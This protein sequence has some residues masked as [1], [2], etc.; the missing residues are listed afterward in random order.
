[1]QT[2]HQRPRLRLV[3]LSAKSVGELHHFANFLGVDCTGCIEKSDLVNRIATSGTVDIIPEPTEEQDTEEQHAE[4]R[5]ATPSTDNTESLSSARLE[6]MSVR[7][8]KAEMTKLSTREG[9]LRKATSSKGLC[10]LAMLTDV[11]HRQSF[12]PL[13]F[14]TGW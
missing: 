9:A 5:H 10:F 12:R 1:M 13:K 2:E 11:S 14:G 3:D 8:I 6:R 7:E 4:E